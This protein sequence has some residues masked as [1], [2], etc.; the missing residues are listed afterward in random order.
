VVATFNDRD[1]AKLMGIN[2][3]LVIT[4]SYALSSATAVLPAAPSDADGA[5]MGPSWPQGLPCCRDH[6]RADQ[7]GHHRWRHHSERAE[8][9]TGFTAISWL[10]GRPDA[11]LL[12]R[13]HSSRLI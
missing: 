8:T 4:F 3:G 13:W 11:V 6:R 7:R 12:L 5:T 10:Q 1:A 9:T 2:T